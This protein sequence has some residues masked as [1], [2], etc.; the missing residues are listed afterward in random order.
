[1]QRQVSLVKQPKKQ[2]FEKF[3]WFKSSD[4]YI[5]VG[6]KDASSNEIIVKKHLEKNDLYFHTELRGAPSTV[7]KKS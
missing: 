6:G 3:R 7:P 1:M 2:W 4:G 5:V